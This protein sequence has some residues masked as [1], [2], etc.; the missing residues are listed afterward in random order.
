[1][2]VALGKTFK[3]KLYKKIDHNDLKD[4]ENNYFKSATDLAL[5]YPMIE[6]SNGRFKCVNEILYVYNH[7][8]SE[9]NHNNST[10]KQK[11]Q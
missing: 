10:K 7:F 3:Y 8:H 6:M 11:Q 9:S 2:V 5:M 1:M 4:K